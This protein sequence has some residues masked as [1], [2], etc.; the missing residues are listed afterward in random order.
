[1]GLPWLC[2]VRLQRAR[3]LRAAGGPRIAWNGCS[4]PPPRLTQWLRTPAW[5]LA[6]RACIGFT[7]RCEGQSTLPSRVRA[8]RV[9]KL[10]MAG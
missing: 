3:K 7:I 1:M 5:T 9:A 2:P 6:C 8:W 10:E 4:G